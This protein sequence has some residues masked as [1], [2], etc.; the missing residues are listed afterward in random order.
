MSRLEAALRLT[1]L[2]FYV[3][4]CIA[5][6]TLGGWWL[7]GK[8][9]LFIIVGLVIGLGMAAYGVYQMIK[10]LMDNKQDKENG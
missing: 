7:G 9:P 10:P 3:G 4:I 6:G 1:G 2:G 8:R 5:G